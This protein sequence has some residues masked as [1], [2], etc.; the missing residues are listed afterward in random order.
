[1]AMPW[2]LISQ[3][4]YRLWR[5]WGRGAY[6]LG[7]TISWRPEGSIC[8][9]KLIGQGVPKGEGAYWP[10]EAHQSVEAYRPGSL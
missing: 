6:R 3:G 2:G 10:R 4:A 7:E 9:R 1:M 5:L 8:H